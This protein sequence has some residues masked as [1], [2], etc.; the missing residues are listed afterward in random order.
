MSSLNPV[1]I[2]EVAAAR[3][4]ALL[5]HAEHQRRV[6]LLFST[7]GPAQRPGTTAALRRALGGALIQ[8]GQRLL[9]LPRPDVA[10]S[11]G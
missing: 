6:A 1:T 2:A 5:A 4:G 9:E 3:T 8:A 11:R 7:Q 10:A